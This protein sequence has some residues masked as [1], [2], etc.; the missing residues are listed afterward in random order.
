VGR[1][2][3]YG[4]LLNVDRGDTRSVRVRLDSDRNRYALDV[5]DVPLMTFSGVRVTRYF[6]LPPDEHLIGA[7]VQA[8][9][10]AANERLD[11]PLTSPWSP[12]LPP[13]S[14]P[15]AREQADRDRQAALDGYGT[16]TVLVAPIS[17]G[18]NTPPACAQP[19]T[20]A[21][22]AQ[23][24][25]PPFPPEA[26][27]VNATGVVEMHLDVDDTGSVVNALITRSSGFAPLDRAA[28]A[29]ARATHFTP[30]TFACHPIA[31]TLELQTGF[32]V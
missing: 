12:D 13:P 14:S 29:A 23:P 11:C 26:R 5:N 28:I 16:H 6:T 9:G 7:W 10:L 22:P 4:I 32:G 24:I 30:A 21:V 19:F 17:F 2:G 15:S 8:T 31:T 20:P 3:T 27:A 25:R 1:A 18:P